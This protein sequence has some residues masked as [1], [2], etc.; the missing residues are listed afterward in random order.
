MATVSAPPEPGTLADL[1]A[2]LGDVPAQRVRLGSGPYGRATEADVLAL[3]RA[4]ERR[5]FELVDG[6]LVEKAMGYR[7]SLLAIFLGGV[8]NDFVLARNL[9]LVT[10]ADGMMRLFPG[11]I[12]IPDVA[13]AAW[14]RFPNRQVPKEPIPDLSPDLAVEILSRSN[15]EKEMALK[16]KDYFE[17]GSRLVWI[18]DPADR[19]AHVYT[20]IDQSIALDESGTLDGA[21]VL[22]GFSLSLRDLFAMLDRHGD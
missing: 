20:A 2:R 18:I 3:R 13:F 7:E 12:R 9:G 5:L 16:R 11:L 8:L 4:P 10:G 22:P 17:S 1:L 15:T 6:V 14:E 21:D 19:T